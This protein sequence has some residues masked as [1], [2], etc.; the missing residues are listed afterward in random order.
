MLVSDFKAN[1]R[2]KI[3]KGI[4]NGI[5]GMPLTRMRRNNGTLPYNGGSHTIFTSST[6]LLDIKSDVYR[7]SGDLIEPNN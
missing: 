4:F 7:S 3:L 5:H 2:L 1:S 6:K